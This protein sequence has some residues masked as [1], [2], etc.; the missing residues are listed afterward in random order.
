VLCDRSA[1]LMPETAA[2]Q[3]GP[4]RAKP[5]GLGQGMAE[6]SSAGSVRLYEAI[7]MG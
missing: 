7:Q 3:I 2:R 1:G 4:G 5:A 6:R